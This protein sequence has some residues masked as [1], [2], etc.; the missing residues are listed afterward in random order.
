MPEH[1]GIDL[2]THL[3][4]QAELTFDSERLGGQIITVRWT[5]EMFNASEPV[6]EVV[7]NGERCALPPLICTSFQLLTVVNDG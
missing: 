4:Y 5:G 1:M 3:A 6:F 2:Q 7:D